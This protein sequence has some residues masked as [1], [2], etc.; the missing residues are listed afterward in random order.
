MDHCTGKGSRRDRR[1]VA[2]SC[3]SAADVLAEGP[4]HDPGGIYRGP[5]GPGSGPTA[6]PEDPAAV[7]VGDAWPRAG[8]TAR[9]PVDAERALAVVCRIVGG[10]PAAV[11][12]W[13]AIDAGPSARDVVAVDPGASDAAHDAGGRERFLD[14]G[15]RSGDRDPGA[16]VA[17]DSRHR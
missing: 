16:D 7:A 4:A 5:C 1:G 13:R 9:R 12:A 3:P 10:G 14:A 15:R 11:D 2:A 8:D 17:V 6:P